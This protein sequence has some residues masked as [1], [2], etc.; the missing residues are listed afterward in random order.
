MSRSVGINYAGKS[1]TVGAGL[2]NVSLDGN[3]VVGVC[4]D[5]AHWNTNGSSYQVNV[6]PMEERGAT[7][8]RA[9]WFFSS[10][11]G[12][13]DSKDKG[14]A[15]QLAIWDILYDGGDGLD[16]GTFQSSVTGAVRSITGTYLTDS[17]DHQSSAA[18]YLKAIT[19]GDNLDMNQ[20]Y[21]VVPEP[22]TVSA[23]VLGSLALLRRRR[24]TA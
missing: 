22:A 24:K 23:M 21:M 1:M 14:A 3:R 12:V 11:V 8:T 13:V 5:L 16:T 10:N 9:A 6:L 7:A 4:V 17:T 18:Y 19:H 20:D 15:L 2:A